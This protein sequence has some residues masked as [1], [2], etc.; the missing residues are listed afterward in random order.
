MIV[1]VHS[2]VGR[3]LAIADDDRCDESG[4]HDEDHAR[5]DQIDI[6]EPGDL[7]GLRGSRQQRARYI[8]G[9]QIT[10]SNG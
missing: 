10:V 7:F 8:H 5:Y 1:Q 2:K 9:Y 6:E 4:D 3:S